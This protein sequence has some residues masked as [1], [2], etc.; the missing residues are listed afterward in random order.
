MKIYL[1][2]FFSVFIIAYNSDLTA[3]TRA[4]NGSVSSDWNN[5]SNWTPSGIP[6]SGIVNINNSMTPFPCILD[7]NRTIA[8]LN[9]NSGASLDFNGFTLTVTGTSTFNN[10]TLS[11]T[12]LTSGNLSGF[13]NNTFN[14]STVLTKTGNLANDL[15][16]G[17]TFNGSLTVTN[18]TTTRLSFSNTTGDTV[19]GNTI[20]NKMGAGSI[21]L[22]DNG[23]SYFDGNVTL[24]NNLT[25]GFFRIGELTGTSTITAGN[26][27]ITSGY[28]T[29]TP[30]LI[31]RLTQLGTTANSTF[32]TNTI[33]FFESSIGGSINTT[34][35]GTTT[36][37]GSS[38]LS[39]TTFTALN[40]S[41]P[42]GNN[43][44]ATT[45]T[46]TG[47]LAE[48]W[49][50][51]NTF[52]DLIF[53]N[54]STVTTTL[55]FNAADIFLG[56]ATFN[57]NAINGGIH[58]ARSGV[59]NFAGN[60]TLNNTTGGTI[61]FGGNGGES[62][63]ASGG[64]LL[65]S[66]Y[67]A[68]TLTL[69]RVT[70]NGT[71]ANGS[72]QPTT[73][74]ANP[75]NNIGG[76]I[77]VVCSGILT[78]QTSL[79]KNSNTFTGSQV[80][81]NGANSLSTV[82]GST[83]IT[84]TGTTIN[85]W[86]GGNTYGELVINNNSTARLSLAITNGDTYLGN[87]TFNKN[88]TGE[89]Q[90]ARNGT[91]TFNGNVKINNAS[92]GNLSFGS[93]TGTSS[94]ASG[95]SILT[96]GF[97]SGGL[98]LRGV[99][100]NGSVANGSFQ[101]A[102]F[103]ADLNNVINGDIS[104]D[105]STSITLANST[106]SATNVFTSPSMA[107]TA[108]NYST[109]SGTTTFTKTGT[110]V[111]EWVGGNTYGDVVINNNSTV[112]LSL[113][114]TNGDTYLGNATFNKN[115]TGELQIARNGTNT[116][117]GNVKI[118]NAST[119]NLSFGSGTGTSSIA[120]GF[121]ILTDGFTSGG[122]ILRG[123]TQNGSVANGSFQPATFSADLNNVING[124]ISIDAST[125]ITLAN[126]TFSA[127]NVFTS[128]SM[129]S[130]A[131]NYS[132]ASGTTTFTKTGTALN[133]WIGGNTFGN[134]IFNLNAATGRLRLASTTADIYN[135][136]A[137]FVRN[138]AAT[139]EPAYNGI[140]LFS[141]NISTLGST[142][143][144]TF[145]A[146]NGRVVFSGS[147]AQTISGD[148]AFKPIFRRI[149]L[150]K[151]SNNV[152]LNVPV[153]VSV[154]ITFT[155]G[156]MNSDA[157]NLLTLLNAATATNASHASFVDGPVRKVGN[158]IFTFPIGNGG[159]YGPIGISAPSNV[160]HHFT[161]QYFKESPDSLG[162]DTD[163]LIGTL[164]HVSGCENW[165]LERTNGTSNV[166]V[167]IH[168][169][170]TRCGGVNIMT[171]LSVGKWDGS[172]WIDL[173]N[174]IVSGTPALGSIRT[175]NLV[176]SFSPFTLASTT[177]NN[178]LPIT[179]TSFDVVA[180]ANNSVSV[181]W[182]TASERENDFFT[183]E[184]SLDGMNW[185]ILGMVAGQGNSIHSVDYTFDDNMPYVGVSYYRLKQTDFNG[186]FEYF[187]PKSVFVDKSNFSEMVVYP[188][189]AFDVLKVQG[190]Q[191][192]IQN[193]TFINAVGQI[194]PCNI[195]DNLSNVNQKSID[196]SNLPQGV[197]YVK[198]STTSKLFIKR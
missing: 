154:N 83:T 60:I 141:G 71:A 54:N 149:T 168:W 31:R 42:N 193:L 32:S 44:N 45:M 53:N 23:N 163:L 186:Q 167:T 75:D 37:Q 108:S 194:I 137:T 173:G 101:P 153:D 181:Q 62:I 112:R 176:T 52:G 139:F 13:S 118:N 10:A 130:N 38:F 119:G 82:T 86:E 135:G 89:L 188:N 12:I 96:D 84:R 59:N 161:A 166:H 102:T 189:P 170:E 3:Q 29:G 142:N 180:S 150:N 111:N 172:Q 90:I 17:N 91:N 157:T 25:G 46:K 77:S 159:F 78:I 117:N 175:L 36:L 50:G 72:F 104:I 19:I 58:I 155:N 116:F 156:K 151:S 68:G 198:G 9:I 184:R 171:E 27:L 146:L 76:S 128:P 94:I 140:N 131:S 165:D 74:N 158:Q 4:W 103:S 145:S 147:N 164:N 34:S 47:G 99:T 148:I 110:T 195:I 174:G 93:G 162:L 11:N 67:T 113:A 80:I 6:S 122:L 114:I 100:Q 115:N 88:N 5:G 24:N 105:A 39:P 178:A 48:N 73:F 69:R 136:N 56:N 57:Q 160:A 182:T 196:V 55:A 95:F 132:T 30:L 40:F 79:F 107:S 190:E 33:T 197:Y 21:E 121:S 87:A 183:V 22:A 7:A 125:S 126:S 187:D 64:A 133:D 177:S 81:L 109:A 51:G 85:E 35:S 1:Y 14:G 2:L 28:V 98:I 129:A 134:V 61:Q 49:N 185:E 106:F 65:T 138:G 26:A 143:P 70:Q 92:T 15:I 127:T 169:D 179:L 97:T 16:G 152:T 8:T 191:N 20:M 18:N 123:V 192:E 41:L 66:G 144:I 43:F 124:D 120:S 63:I